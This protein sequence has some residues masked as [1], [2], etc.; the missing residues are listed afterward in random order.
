MAD[1]G[2]FVFGDLSVK[3]EGEYRLK[4][5]LF[6]MFRFV[7]RTTSCYPG[8]NICTRTEVIYLQAIVS[9]PFVGKIKHLPVE[10]SSSANSEHSP[11]RQELSW[12]GRVDLSL[13]VI[14]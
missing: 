14:R 1:G 2:F 7:L 13:E 9:K 5:S 12:N 4:F 10:F 11:L 3:L 6:E 8:S